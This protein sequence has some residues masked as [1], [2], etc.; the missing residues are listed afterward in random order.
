[1]RATDGGCF[2]SEYALLMGCETI[3]EKREENRGCLWRQE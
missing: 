2:M 1:M 3:E